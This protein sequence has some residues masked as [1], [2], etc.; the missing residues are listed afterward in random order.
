MEKKLQSLA[1]VSV[2][3]NKLTSNNNEIVLL[4]SINFSNVSI[5][6]QFTQQ[7]F[8]VLR[9]VFSEKEIAKFRTA[10]IE[11]LPIND[12]P[13]NE[14]F[15]SAIAFDDP[16][17]R[18]FTNKRVIGI[19]KEI[20][21]EDF[22]YF[23]QHVIHDSS[24]GGWHTDTGSPEIIGSHEFHWAPTF[25]A[26]QCV[27]YFQSNEEGSFGL[28]IIPRS[29]LIDDHTTDGHQPPA[30]Y[31][32]SHDEG[33]GIQYHDLI[34]NQT[35]KMESLQLD[36]KAGDVVFFHVRLVHRAS[37]IKFQLENNSERKFAAFA[38]AGANNLSSRRYKSWL[39]EYD[40]MNEVNRVEIPENYRRKLSS[41]GVELL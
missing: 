8:A 28:D 13:F 19:C 4:S 33:K 29:H 40:I 15:S 2:L 22:I 36:T 23:N 17:D 26:V 34:Q 6:R 12:F 14:Q 11:K 7:G 5:A 30:A 35:G 20:M 27:L 18:V 32:K 1:K 10:A 16:F 24:R 37:P 38:V 3:E 41:F 39:D 21:G 9:G 31:K 25:L